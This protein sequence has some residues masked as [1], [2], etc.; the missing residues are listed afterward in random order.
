MQNAKIGQDLSQK[1]CPTCPLKTRGPSS[2]ASNCSLHGEKV[3]LVK[4]VAYVSLDVTAT[5]FYLLRN[6]HQAD[7]AE[8]IEIEHGR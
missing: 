1:S 7:H 4:L 3:Y 8:D 2:D 5:I 6:G